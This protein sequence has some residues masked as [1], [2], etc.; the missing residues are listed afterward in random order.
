[1]IVEMSLRIADAVM[2]EMV[3]E[4]GNASVEKRPMRID[5]L[6]A[7]IVGG[8]GVDCEDSYARSRVDVN[9]DKI[10]DVAV[11]VTRLEDKVRMIE[12]LAHGHCTEG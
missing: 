4:L 6:D 9:S 1:M 8:A 5:L 7:V 12:G 11:G 3:T 10:Y 2:R